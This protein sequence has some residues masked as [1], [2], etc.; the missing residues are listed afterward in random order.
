MGHLSAYVRFNAKTGISNRKSLKN[1]V[2]Y[3]YTNS[4]IALS[5][6]FEMSFF[7]QIGQEMGHF[8]AHA[9]KIT[10][11]VINHPFPNISGFMQKPEIQTVFRYM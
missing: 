9:L 2:S 5:H 4:K 1:P 11:G 6:S 7:E 8:R 10:I 3:S